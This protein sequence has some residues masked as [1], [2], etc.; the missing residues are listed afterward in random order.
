MCDKTHNSSSFDLKLAVSVSW[1]ANMY[2]SQLRDDQVL[3]RRSHL[4]ELHVNMAPKYT[5]SVGSWAGQIGLDWTPPTETAS[6]FFVSFPTSKTGK[7]K[8]RFFSRRLQIEG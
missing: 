6:L 4:V 8:P 7:L 1:L 3:R 5:L 2:L